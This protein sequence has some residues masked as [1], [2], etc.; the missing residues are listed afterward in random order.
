MVLILGLLIA[1]CVSSIVW[2]FG[3]SSLE[4]RLIDQRVRLVTQAYF[5]RPRTTKVDLFKPAFVEE[6]S[7]FWSLFGFQTQP[8]LNQI[9]MVSILGIVSTVVVFSFF[10]GVLLNRALIAFLL[11]VIFSRFI[12]LMIRKIRF[13]RLERELPGALDLIVICLEAGLGLNSAFLRVANEMEGSIVGKELKQTSNEVSAGIPLEYALR[14]FSKRTGISDVQA[15]VAAIIQ[16]QK[17]GSGL[18]TTFRVQANALREKSKMRIREK[19]AKIPIK[20]LFPL[21]FFIFPTIF[22]VIL[23]PALISIKNLNITQ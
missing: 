14:N 20:I 1:L 15:I 19:I 2:Y 3:E 9:L 18:A 17:L 22:L 8:K 10:K 13:T 5:R 7:F 4:N 16:A 21:V 6:R 11:V 12:N 23:G